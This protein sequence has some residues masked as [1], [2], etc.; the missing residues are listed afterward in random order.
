MA[1][2]LLRFLHIQQPQEI[3]RWLSWTCVFLPSLDAV[4][5]LTARLYSGTAGLF[6]PYQDVRLLGR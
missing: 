2:D 3:I 4:I 6:G 1:M 5:G